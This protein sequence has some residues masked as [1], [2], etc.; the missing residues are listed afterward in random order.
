MAE[1]S[2][3]AEGERRDSAIL[4]TLTFR[5][6][7]LMNLMTRPF[8]ETHGALHGL[9][10][11]E[12]R[13]LMWLAGV[14]GVSGEDTASGTGMDRMSVSRALRALEG[15]GLLERRAD[16]RNRRRSEWRLTAAGWAIYEAIAPAAL[17]RDQDLTAGLS[18][19]ERD[20]LHN[21]I[22]AAIDS[23]RRAQG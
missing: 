19:E 6:I 1:A 13:C 10:L 5:L 2:G 14:P 23:L 18:A 22:E 7:V 9:S 3:R 8:A 17:A 20:V 16:P 15:R 4:E 11:S 21:A 12:W